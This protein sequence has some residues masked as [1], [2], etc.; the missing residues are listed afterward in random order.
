VESALERADCVAGSVLS[1]KN[2]AALWLDRKVDSRLGS[3][4]QAKRIL[5]NT[6][7]SNRG[8]RRDDA[9]FTWMLRNPSGISSNCKAET[10]R[11]RQQRVRCSG[12]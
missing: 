6:S 12:E 1:V 3:N 5:P 4:Q 7:I 2:F 9:S 10:C 8:R 11:F